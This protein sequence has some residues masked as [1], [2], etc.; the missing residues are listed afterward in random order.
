M[1]HAVAHKKEAQRIL[2]SGAD[3]WGKSSARG[4]TVLHHAASA[5]LTD[6]CEL[7]LAK[8]SSLVHAMDVS[9]STALPHAVADGPIHCEAAAATWC[10]REQIRGASHNTTSN[11]SLCK[12]AYRHGCFAAHR[13][14]RCECS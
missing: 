5:A 7:L 14:C 12:R 9:G 10:R 8:E 4:M 11:N 1:V 13:R 6:R 2:Q 3:V